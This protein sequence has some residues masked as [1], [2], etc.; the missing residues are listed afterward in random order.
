MK[1]GVEEDIKELL[2]YI[3]ACTEVAVV[4]SNIIELSEFLYLLFTP[5]TMCQ[6]QLALIEISKEQY[7]GNIV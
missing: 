6:V 4:C 1:E 3:M 2:C 5:A 7:T